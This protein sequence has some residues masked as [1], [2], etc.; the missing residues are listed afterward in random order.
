VEEAKWNQ[1]A[2]AY[3]EFEK[4]VALQ[5]K[6]QLERWVPGIELV[7][8][9]MGGMIEVMPDLI[10]AA[11]RAARGQLLGV[12]TPAAAGL[13]F[14][15]GGPKGAIVAATLKAALDQPEFKSKLAIA[16]NRA[17]GLKSG[18]L[19]GKLTPLGTAQRIINPQT[20]EQRELRDGQWV[21]VQ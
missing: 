16:I 5:A 9:R 8:E 21:P 4:Q 10:A 6:D 12:G 19:T 7:N 2:D 20:G 14:A 11:R 15:T 1:T 13:G 3:T 18:R 17:Q